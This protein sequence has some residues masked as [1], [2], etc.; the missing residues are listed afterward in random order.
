[1]KR[2][3]SKWSNLIVGVACALATVLMS[4]GIMRGYTPFNSSVFLLALL[5]IGFIYRGVLRL[6]GNRDTNKR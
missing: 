4:V 3:Y 6:R 5:T 2:W 1:M